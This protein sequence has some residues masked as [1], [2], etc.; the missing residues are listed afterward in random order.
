[1][2]YRTPNWDTAHNILN[3]YDIRYVYVGDLERTTYP[4]QEEKFQRNLIQ[5]FNKGNVTIYEV[6]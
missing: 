4:V 1:M 6:P 3:K 2:L 5:V